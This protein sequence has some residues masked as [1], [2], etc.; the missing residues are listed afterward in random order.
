MATRLYGVAN[1]AAPVSPAFDSGWIDTTSAV[2]RGLSLTKAATT[3]TRSAVNVTSGAGNNALAFQLISDPLDAQTITGGTVTLMCRGREL[4]TTDNVNKRWRVTKIISNDGSTVRAVMNS[5]QATSSTTELGTSLSGQIM[6]NVAGTGT[7]NVQA[8]DRILVEVGYGLSSTGTSP[9]YDMVIGGNGTD[10]AV[11]EGD[12]TGTVA[13]I[14]FSQ[15]LVFL[16]PEQQ[17]SADLT[18]SASLVTT[19]QALHVVNGIEFEEFPTDLNSNAGA[20]SVVSASRTF[21]AGSLG[22]LV[23]TANGPS[24]SNLTGTVTDSAGNTWTLIEDQSLTGG[25]PGFVGAY[26]RAF[27]SQTTATVTAA[28]SIGAGAN[29]LASKLYIIRS[30]YDST[31]PIGSSAP[32]T[33]TAATITTAAITPQTT[34]LI[35]SG[36]SDWTA[37]ATMNSSDLVEDTWTISGQASGS[38]GYEAGSA[39][40]SNSSSWVTPDASQ[41]NTVIFEIRAGGPATQNGSAALTAT[42]SLVAT[43]TVTALASASLA[44]SSSLAATGVVTKVASASL[45]ASSSLAATGVVSKIA[46]ASLTAT[47]SLS[48]SATLAGFGAAGLTASAQLAVAGIVTRLGTAALTAGATLGASGVVTRLGV[49]NLAASSDLSTAAVVSKLASAALAA[50]STLAATGTVIGGASAAADLIAAASLSASGVVT[51]PGTAAL[52]AASSLSTT[53]VVTVLGSVAIVAGATL[54][55]AGTRTVLGVAALTADASLGVAATVAGQTAAALVASATLA[56]SGQR[57]AIATAALTAGSAFSVAGVVGKLSAVDLSASSL[58]AVSGL[59]TVLGVVTL[60]AQSTLTVAGLIA[61]QTEA[62]LVASSLLTVAGQRIAVAPVALLAAASLSGL[63]V[64][65]VP[66]GAALTGTAALSVSAR[67]DQKAIAQLVAIAVLGISA[68]THTPGFVGSASVSTRPG[69]SSSVR[70]RSTGAAGVAISFPGSA[71]VTVR[72]G[73]S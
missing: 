52:S 49:A 29:G 21:P 55:A 69:S 54:T 26:R 23:V 20:T 39:G 48:A 34:G 36:A 72:K 42:A 50:S 62:D 9:Q 37:P 40:V 58:F 51:R 32:G 13:W 31:T 56:I 60:N 33:S 25:Q 10:H 2:R 57:T 59:V 65:V 67:L 64:V 45:T 19:G 14:E 6:A 11:T 53:G 73:A 30:G 68:N 12:T 7:V 18:A 16:P 38:V 27:A 71:R 35:I 8:G 41:A 44:A 47:A 17:G 43:G 28:V 5:M 61:G 66:A 4:A 63:G 15:N 22:I 1:T 24:G 70:V 46:S 3:E